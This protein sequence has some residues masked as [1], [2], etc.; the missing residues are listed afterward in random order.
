LDRASDL[1]IS[2][3]KNGKPIDKKF[4]SFID[5]VPDSV[6]SATKDNIILGALSCGLK[7]KN[8]Y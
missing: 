6:P 8:P 4:E 7:N 1:I 3:Y 2:Y 5:G